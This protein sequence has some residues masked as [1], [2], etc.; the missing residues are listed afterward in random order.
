MSTFSCQWVIRDLVGREHWG[1]TRE[2]TLPSEVRKRMFHY[3]YTGTSY[4][5]LWAAEDLVVFKR[6]E[7]LLR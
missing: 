1:R 2:E 7:A 3:K 6:A 4:G 5:D